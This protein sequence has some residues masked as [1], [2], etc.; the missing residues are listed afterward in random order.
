MADEGHTRHQYYPSKEEVAVVGT[1]Q[2]GKDF[3]YH[4]FKDGADNAPSSIYELITTPKLESF[5]ISKLGKQI[6]KFIISFFK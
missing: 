5:I 4:N 6:I 1:I 3:I 2:Q